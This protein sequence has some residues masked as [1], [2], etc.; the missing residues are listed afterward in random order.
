EIY[1]GEEIPNINQ[2]AIRLKNKGK[3]YF[4]SSNFLKDISKNITE[5][6]DKTIFSYQA[7]D[8]SFIEIQTRERKI[9]LEKKGK[10]WYLD[11]PFKDRAQKDGVEDLIYGL[12]S[13]R[14]KEFIDEYDD[15]K[16]KELN[17]LPPVAT[18]SFYDKDKKLILQG[19]FGKTEKLEKNDFYVKTGK[20]V[21]LASHSLW[22][23]LEKGLVAIPDTKIL[24]FSQWEVKKF[25]LKIRGEEYSFEK[26]DEKW[27]LGG[28][29]IKNEK[30]VDE[31][32]KE[33]AEMSWV[34]SISNYKDVEEIGELEVEGENLKLKC[35]F[36]RD[37]RDRET[38]WANPEDRPNLW[39][40]VPKVWERVE[41]ELKKLKN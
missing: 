36:F 24:S 31:I 38:F 6:R 3:S 25:K 27:F 32:L 26:K 39:S 11:F 35:K 16:L 5:L 8:V 23:K 21:F 9:N 2:L 4:V 15:E 17:L 10:F 14:A 37:L 40:F 28:K 30:P 20:R 19:E 29:E 1:I 34:K 22:E 7:S 33:F 12:S 18:L 41:E 13:F